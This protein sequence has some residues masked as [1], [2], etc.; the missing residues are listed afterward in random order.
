MIRRIFI[1]S[2]QRELAKERKAIVRLVS[3]NPQ[4][5]RFFTTFAFEFDVPAE[6]KR[7][8]A[9]ERENTQ[10]HGYKSNENDQ[11]SL[12]HVFFTSSQS[13]PGLMTTVSSVFWK[14]QTWILTG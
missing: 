6:D 13:S 2:V 11:G 8:D 4:L 9:C 3:G 7:T 14:A 5:S 12:S 10:R 1:S